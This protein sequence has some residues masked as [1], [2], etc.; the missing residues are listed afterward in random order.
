MA[1]EGAPAVVRLIAQI[2][3]KFN[4]HVSQKAAAM[5]VPI[6]GAAGGA[7]VNTLFI[8]HFQEMA[9]GHFTVRRLERV[10]GADVVGAAYRALNVS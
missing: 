3:A 10:Y 5:L 9:H 6:V 8:H 1:K 4:V 7:L 2:G